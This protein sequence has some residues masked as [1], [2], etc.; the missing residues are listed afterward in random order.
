MDQATFQP[1]QE[2]VSGAPPDQMSHFCCDAAHNGGRRRRLGDQLL[3][4][5]DA[6]CP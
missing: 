4:C 5:E 1:F 2:Q 6:F 3:D